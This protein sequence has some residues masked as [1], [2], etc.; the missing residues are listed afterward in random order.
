MLGLAAA[1]H[2]RQPALPLEQR[3][4]EQVLR[5][6]WAAAV[7]GGSTIAAILPKV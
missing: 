3:R 1:Q 7:A 6:R 2:R 5:A 4:L